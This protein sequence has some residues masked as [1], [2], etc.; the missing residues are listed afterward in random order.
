MGFRVRYKVLTTE[1]DPID[2]SKIRRIDVFD[3]HTAKTREEAQKQCKEYVTKKYNLVP[4]SKG[5]RPNDY[6]DVENIMTFP[7]DLEVK[8]EK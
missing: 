8:K 7:E 2:G 4:L 1:I 5:T 3:T 6:S